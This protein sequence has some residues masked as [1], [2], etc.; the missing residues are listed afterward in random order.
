MK[1]KI[2]TIVLFVIAIIILIISVTKNCEV[3][4]TQD[5]MLDDCI[6]TANEIGLDPND[7]QRAEFIKN[8]YVYNDQ[9]SE[10]Q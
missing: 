8:C 2:T 3:N 10:I 1:N 6:T 4:T 9:H 7:D 5:K